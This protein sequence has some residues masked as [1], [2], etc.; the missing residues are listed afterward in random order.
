MLERITERGVSL[1]HSSPRIKKIMKLRKE[2]ES[3]GKNGQEV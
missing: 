1:M 2:R 3:V